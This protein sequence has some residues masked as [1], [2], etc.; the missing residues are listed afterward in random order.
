MTDIDSPLH[1]W[2]K[3]IIQECITI[4]ILRN[5]YINPKLLSEA[6]LNRQFDY[7]KIP[8][9][10]PGIKVISFEP[11]DNRGSWATHRTLGW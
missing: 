11:P 8:L 7:N 6:H 10:P 3:L 9:A 4:K 1:L 5:L 2:D